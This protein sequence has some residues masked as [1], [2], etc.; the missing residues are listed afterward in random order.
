MLNK[1]LDFL[2]KKKLFFI[3]LGISLLFAGIDQITKILVFKK[4]TYVSRMTIGLHRHIKITSFFNLVKV[5]N[6]GVSFGMFNN[7][8]NGQVILSI[9]TLLIAGF[10][11]YLLWKSKDKYSMIYLSLIFGGAI[12][13]LIDRIRFGAVADFLDF[14]IGEL[15]WPA[16]NIADSIVCIGV[17]MIL[18]EGFVKRKLEAK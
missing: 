5:W 8:A 17:F 6:K 7:L 3:G 16:F 13:N 11:L 2:K 9:L 18:I 12:G 4:L 10:V 14:H 1:V 15:H